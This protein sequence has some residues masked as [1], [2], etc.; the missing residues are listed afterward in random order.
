MNTK[1]EWTK[2]GR[3]N[4]DEWKKK[5]MNEQNWW[6]NEKIWLHTR[7]RM[8]KKYEWTNTLNQHKK[9]EWTNK[10]EWTT[11]DEW[12]KKNEQTTRINK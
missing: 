10:Y 8:N 6:M 12:S 5:T 7:R 11:N 2:N 3:I 9:Y 1:Y 4:A